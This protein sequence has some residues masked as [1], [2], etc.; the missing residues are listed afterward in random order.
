MSAALKF[1]PH[2]TVDDYSLWKG[3]WELWE[4]LAIAMSPSPLGVHQDVVTQLIRMLGNAVEAP[5]FCRIQHVKTTWT[6]SDSFTIAK[7][8]ASI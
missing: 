7:E 3:D 6:I 1:A 4:G 5:R 2:Y 8:W